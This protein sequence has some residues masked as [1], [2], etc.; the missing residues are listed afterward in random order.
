L[1]PA[2]TVNT[3]FCDFQELYNLHTKL[4]ELLEKRVEAWDPITGCIG[5]LF[6][7]EV[8]FV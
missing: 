3:I 6:L 7:R 2:S 5:D 1:V 8:R 4:L